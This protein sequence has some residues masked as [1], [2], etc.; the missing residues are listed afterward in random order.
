ME[1]FEFLD[2]VLQG[3]AAG[4]GVG[5][6]GLMLVRTT[7]R[8]ALRIVGLEPEP[9]FDPRVAKAGRRMALL[10]G[11]CVFV[12]VVRTFGAVV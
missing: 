10:F 8:G 5:L 11:I 12:V 4:S 1:L 6:I 2:P 3:I 7:P 9:L